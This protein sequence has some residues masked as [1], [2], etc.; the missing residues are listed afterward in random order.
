MNARDRQRDGSGPRGFMLAHKFLFHCRRVTWQV[1]TVHDKKK[2]SFFFS[3]AAA[4]L[5]VVDC[6]ELNSCYRICRWHSHYAMNRAEKG[7]KGIRVAVP[8]GKKKVKTWHKSKIS[9]IKVV[10]KT[11][12]TLVSSAGSW[13]VP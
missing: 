8:L 1:T 11:A 9:S 7:K 4:A 5:D 10:S 3:T 2:R 12:I 13:A 6:D